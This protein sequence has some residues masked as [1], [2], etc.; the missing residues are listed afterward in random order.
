MIIVISGPGGVGKGTVVR[1]LMAD[2][3]ELRLSRS[4]T[5]RDLRPGEDPESYTFV[6]EDEFRAAIDAGGFLEWDHHFLAYYGSPVPD[7]NDPADLVL[8]I[9]VNGAKQ[10][11][12]Q[13]PDALFI[14]IDT[15]SLDTQ[16]ERLIGRG[17]TNE[18]VER[19]MAAGE[20]ERGLAAD[21]PYTHV[22]NG[23]VARAATEI[24]ALIESH[25]EPIES[26]SSC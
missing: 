2:Q 18:Q 4:W 11:F 1:Q 22:I 20:A 7:P 9:D 6:S 13:R 24:A 17:D 19:R 10:I 12:E 26:P 3:P 15:P 25:R 5:T 14:F 21:L 23:D 16:R 8:E